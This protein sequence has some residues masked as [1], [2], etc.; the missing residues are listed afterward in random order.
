MTVQARLLRPGI[1][2]IETPRRHFCRRD[3]G[4]RSAAD[5]SSTAP[6]YCLFAPG[7]DPRRYESLLDGCDAIE[8]DPRGSVLDFCSDATRG[9][10]REQ[11]SCPSRPSVL[12]FPRGGLDFQH[13]RPIRTERSTQARLEDATR[14]RRDRA[15]D[16]SRR[17]PLSPHRHSL[18]EKSEQGNRYDRGLDPFQ[19]AT[20][21]S[22]R[23]PA[24]SIRSDFGYGGSLRSPSLGPGPRTVYWAFAFFLRVRKRR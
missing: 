24:S 19:L 11:W 13:L 21:G 15:P 9:H 8:R 16:C 2:S 20:A 22:T 18:G 10:I 4:T 6:A 5:A 23:D 3:P 7:I 14:S 1:P 12:P 17:M